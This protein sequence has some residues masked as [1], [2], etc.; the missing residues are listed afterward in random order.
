MFKHINNEQL[1]ELM[2]QQKINIVD[3]RD[4]QS[5]AAGHIPLAENLNNENVNEYINKTDKSL[6]VVVCCYHGNSSQGAAQ[7]LFEQ[8]FQQAYSLDGGFEEWKTRQPK[9][10]ESS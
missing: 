5:F 7:F 8:G 9:D 3:T 1:T 10:I 2:T 4:G 6:P